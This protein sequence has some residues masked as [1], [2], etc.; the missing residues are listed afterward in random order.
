MQPDSSEHIHEFE[1]VPNAVETKDLDL[2][3]IVT[4]A[5]PAHNER[6]GTIVQKRLIEI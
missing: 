3:G 2:T 6:P 4:S 1:G 5:I